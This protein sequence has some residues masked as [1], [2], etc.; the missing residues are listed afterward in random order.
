MKHIIQIYEENSV[1]KINLDKSTLFFNPNIKNESMRKIQE[2]FGV[3]S[4]ES[5]GKYLGILA[6]VGKDKKMIFRNL[7]ER[8]EVRVKS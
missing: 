1:Q 8:M 6:L 4:I 7:K 5:M 3:Q 2:L